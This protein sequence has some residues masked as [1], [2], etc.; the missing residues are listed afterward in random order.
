MAMAAGALDA[1]RAAGVPADDR[2]AVG[3]FSAGTAGV[4]TDAATGP[5]AGGGRSG[6]GGIGAGAGAGA[7]ARSSSGLAVRH[8]LSRGCPRTTLT[9][10]ALVVILNGNGAARSITTRVTSGRVLLTA[11]RILLI[12]ESRLVVTAAVRR[13]NPGK[14]RK[15][16]GGPST[17]PDAGVT[18]P[19]A[20]S[21]ETVTV[22]AFDVIAIARTARAAP[23]P[24]G[25][26]SSA[27]RSEPPRSIASDSTTHTTTRNA[28]LEERGR[29]R[30]LGRKMW[31]SAFTIVLVQGYRRRGSES[32]F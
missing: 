31:W 6:T 25:V 19:P 15:I 2:F 23:P 13:P 26:L 22:S 29:P 28:A 16:L 20:T 24:C 18:A 11:A 32:T 8:L 5:G 4:A 14:S 12:R 7:G 21:I 30:R 10:P 3:G 17:N 27:A 9:R 1:G